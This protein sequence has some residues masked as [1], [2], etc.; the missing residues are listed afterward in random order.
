MKTS[1]FHY[2]IKAHPTSFDGVAF[3]SRLEARWAAFFSL[4]RWAWEY[5][6]IDLDG[7]SP[8]FRV[9]I[10]CGHSECN[11]A[12]VLFAEVKPFWR[13]S[14]FDGHPCTQF[15]YGVQWDFSG[16]TVIASIDADSS[17]LLGASP[18][19]THWQM[20]HGCGGGEF[21]VPFFVPNYDAL[22]KQAGNLTQW[23]TKKPFFRKSTQQ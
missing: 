2:N 15:M 16:E 20:S 23:Q 5:E 22:W 9:V 13:L 11:G 18:E 19:V 6:P 8:D 10:P 17:A 7:W 21:D 3:R 1:S 14:Q 4:A 12:H